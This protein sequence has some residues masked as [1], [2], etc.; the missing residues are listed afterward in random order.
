M[1][2]AIRHIR[3][4]KKDPEKERPTFDGNLEPNNGINIV[5]LTIST[6][7]MRDETIQ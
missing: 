1:R 4:D 5:C 3:N 6:T 7:E 2:Y